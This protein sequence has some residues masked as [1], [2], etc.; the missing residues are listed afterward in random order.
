MS[1]DP[2]ESMVAGPNTLTIVRVF[3]APRELVFAA[4]T[5]PDRLAA[6]WGPAELHTPRESVSIDPRVGG[7]WSATMVMDDGSAEF[8][9]AGTFSR[10]EPPSGFEMR[11]EAT[12]MF[13]FANTMT[14]SLDEVEN[15]TRMTI[16]QHFATESFDFGDS[17][18]GWGSSLEKLR[19]LMT[20]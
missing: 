3:N 5:D 13:P 4:W 19:A 2:G 20:G 18:V 1:R 10:F 14:V 9:S 15:G 17:I 8:P 7:E 16:V 11:E 6:W 12:D